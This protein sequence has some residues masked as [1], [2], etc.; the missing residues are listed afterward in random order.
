MTLVLN[1]EERKRWFD[2]QR[3]HSV[4]TITPSGSYVTGGDVLSFADPNIKSSRI[5]EWVEIHGIAGFAY[6][7]SEQTD[8]TDGLMLVH[9]GSTEEAAAAYDA[10]ILADTITYH[11]IFRMR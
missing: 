1:T 8:Q 5:P 4:G 11:A 3:F 7:Y 9:D 6:S 2:G 10:A